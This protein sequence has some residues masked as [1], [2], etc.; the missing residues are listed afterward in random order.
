MAKHALQ[1]KMKVGVYARVS[2]DDQHTSIENQ[3]DIFN[4][5]I[6]QNDAEIY[7]VYTDEAISGTKGYKRKDWQ[8]L[9][10]DI[11]TKKFQILLVKSFS[12][13]GRN[14]RET[15]DVIAKL[16]ANNIRF[17]FLEDGIDSKRD[18][19]TVGLFAWLAEQEAQRTSERLKLVWSKY[20]EDGIIH[21]CLPPYG[22]DYDSNIRN[23]IIN[24][25]E[26]KIIRRIYNMYIQGYGFTKIA[27]ILREEKVNTKKGGDWANA[28][29][30]K[31]LTNEVYVGTL[32]QGMSR[33]IDVTLN[34]REIIPSEKWHRHPNHHPAIIT[35]DMFFKVQ[36]LMQERSKYAENFY[37]NGKQPRKASRHS[38]ASLFSNLLICGECGST[39]SIKRKKKLNN[40][41]PF[42]NCI[43]Y[44]LKG[45]QY[46]GHTSNFIWENIL[47]TIIRDELERQAQNDFQ[48]LKELLKQNRSNSQ[49]K[50]VEIELK[51]INAKIEQHVK[52]SMTLQIN[53]DKGLIGDTQFKLQNEMIEKNLNLLMARKDVLE[54]TPKEII[55][56]N[57]ESILIEG[58]NELLSLPAEEWTN[59]LLKTILNKITIYINGTIHVDIKYLNDKS[60]YGS[61]GLLGS[62][63]ADWLDNLIPIPFLE[64][65]EFEIAQ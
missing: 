15:L 57:E 21:V 33:S 48:S 35:E 17:I 38:N 16:K 36:A 19:T 37:L 29:I 13:F 14:Q 10:E 45:K 47:S 54:N 28:T 32:I 59:A 58:I 8:R 1:Q 7:D 22:Y 20:N 3:H 52:L 23:Y 27:N 6:K 46:C 2:T 41:T 34:E 55:R 40:Y 64:D 11:N 12:R 49:P 30:R 53:H 60:G 18:A 43:A 44:E 42:Y 65:I 25:E 24:E 39:M 31:M 26:S 9:I 56:T 62:E 5:W 61:I 4:K 51:T 63:F 50:S